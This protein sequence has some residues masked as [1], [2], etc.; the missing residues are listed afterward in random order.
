MSPWIRKFLFVA[1][2]LVVLGVI[3]G[4]VWAGRAS[5]APRAS[6][7]GKTARR[8]F[9]EL[10]TFPNYKQS[11][12]AFEVMGTNALPFLAGELERQDSGCDRLYRRMYPKLPSVMKKHFVRPVP[13]SYR[14]NFAA[15]CMT[16]PCNQRMAVPEL[17]RILQRPGLKTEQT[18][19]A[20]DCISGIVGPQDT[21]CVPLLLKFLVSTNAD[22]RAFAALGLGQIGPAAKAAVPELTRSLHH[23]DLYDR[24]TALLSLKGIGPEAKS[25]EPDVLR[26]L[27][28]DDKN[29][30]YFAMLALEKIDPQMAAERKR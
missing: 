16:L 11:Q 14:W 4:V 28:S 3:A 6:Y 9:A 8:W 5:T 19:M 7:Q 1:L 29:V 2:A 24:M 18:S 15:E 12:H 22:Q 10:H 13:E 21:N 30:C 26:L 27:D 23:S 25:A 17:C 20:L